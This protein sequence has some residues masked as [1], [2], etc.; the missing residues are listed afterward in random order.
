MRLWKTTNICVADSWIAL[1]LSLRSFSWINWL[2]YYQLPFL[3]SWGT[4][5][6]LSCISVFDQMNGILKCFYHFASWIK[7]KS[8]FQGLVNCVCLLSE[9]KL[10]DVKS[11]RVHLCW[12]TKF[13]LWRHKRKFYNL[14]IIGLPFSSHFVSN[15][16][17]D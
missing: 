12:Y 15:S 6:R 4:H 8:S 17:C 1:A 14:A 9:E 7:M 10:F 11:F 2:P 16:T 3:R 5:F 13:R